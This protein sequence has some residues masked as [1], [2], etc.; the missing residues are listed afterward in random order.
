MTQSK[1]P[2]FPNI[3]EAPKTPT[4]HDKL[5][6][7]KHRLLN[8]KTELLQKHRILVPL[9]N[10]RN[11]KE[12]ISKCIFISTNMKCQN[13]SFWPHKP[14]VKMPTIGCKDQMPKRPIFDKPNKMP[15]SQISDI[16]PHRRNAKMPKSQISDIWP[17]RRNAKMPKC[18]NPRFLTYDR[19]DEM[20]KWQNDKMSKCQNDKMPTKCQNNNFASKTFDIITINESFIQKCSTICYNLD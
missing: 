16:W 18:Q 8:T 10:A 9:Q 20:P 13:A 11:Q 2:T 12:Q 15:K 4:F 7:S 14:N 3:K 17:N 5:K 6:S 1:I 19:I